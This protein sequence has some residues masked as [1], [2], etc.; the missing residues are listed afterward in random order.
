MTK[1]SDDDPLGYRRGKNQAAEVAGVG[2]QFAGAIVLFMFVGRWLDGKLGT[3]P[4]LLLLG[5][6]VGAVGG[7]YSMYR[8]LVILPRQRAKGK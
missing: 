7:F 5:V 2:L 1:R 8:Q 4:W 6:V 3:D